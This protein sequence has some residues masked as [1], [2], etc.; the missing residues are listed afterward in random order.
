MQDSPFIIGDLLNRELAEHNLGQLST[1]DISKND[2]LLNPSVSRLA[3][4]NITYISSQV[5]CV[6]TAR[7]IAIDWLG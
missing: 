5:K 1:E 4:Y 6:W 3:L 2:D 7:C